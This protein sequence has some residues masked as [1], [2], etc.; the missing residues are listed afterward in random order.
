M[1]ALAVAKAGALCLALV[2][3][4]MPVC[5]TEHGPKYICDLDRGW[6]YTPAQV[7][8]SVRLSAKFYGA[9]Q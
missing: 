6:C 1:N 2:N 5:S 3:P 4:K 8:R 7:A 9:K